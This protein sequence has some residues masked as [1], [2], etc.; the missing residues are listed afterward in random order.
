M[1]RIDAT[2]SG[3]SRSGFSPSIV[4]PAA[5]AARLPCKI[6]WFSPCAF[7]SRMIM[8]SSKAAAR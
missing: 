5:I 6:G 1:L 3:G 8:Q 7:E 4:W 2:T